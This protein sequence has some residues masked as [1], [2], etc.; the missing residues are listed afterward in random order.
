MKS[1]R[2]REEVGVGGGNDPKVPAEANRAKAL[3]GSH[4]TGRQPPRPGPTTRDGNREARPVGGLVLSAVAV[5]AE[6]ARV[7]PFNVA[8]TE[9]RDAWHPQA[10]ACPGTALRPRPLLVMSL[11]PG[12]SGGPSGTCRLQRG[13]QGQQGQGRR[14]RL[15]EPKS[16]SLRLAQ[17][18]QP[19]A[20]SYWAP[21]PPRSADPDRKLARPRPAFRKGGLVL[22]RPP[23]RPVT[24]PPPQPGPA[25]WVSQGGRDAGEGRESRQLGLGG[26]TC[27]SK[28]STLGE[29]G[30]T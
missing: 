17:T 15:L 21:T 14:P 20:C 13:A 4:G 10:V 22:L 3:H 1:A 11:P 28:H 24:P 2:W 5:P 16:R 7:K 9:G 25:L 29:Q 30:G 19:T 18:T 6:R 27:P 8:L 26:G 12:G 23:A